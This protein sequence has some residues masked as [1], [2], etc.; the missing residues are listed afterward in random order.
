MDE[1]AGQVQ[2]RV[3]FLLTQ[4]QRDCSRLSMPVTDAMLLA[5]VC[6]WPLTVKQSMARS[7]DIQQMRKRQLEMLVEGQ[8][9]TLS[10]GVTNLEKK[11]EKIA[12]AGSLAPAEVHTI[13]KRISGAQE[14][15]ATMIAEAGD[16][17]RQEKLLQMALTDNKTRLNVV[18]KALAPLAQLWSVVRAWV[19]KIN[20][21]QHDPLNTVDAQDAEKSTTELR[22]ALGVAVR[23]L[24][25]RGDARATP[26]RAGKLLQQ[27]VKIFD[28]EQL[29]LL[30]LVCQ[31]GMKDRHWTQIKKNTRL[32]SLDI[33]K[34]SNLLQMLDVGLQHYAGVIEESCVAAGHEHGLEQQLERMEGS[35]RTMN[36]SII[37]WRGF[38]KLDGTLDIQQV[39]AHFVA[40]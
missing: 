3:H 20:H 30:R 5:S 14:L 4:T 11:I 9:E 32:D 40:L 33:T 12:E 2:E 38:H 31:P 24:E 35:W 15:L 21:W 28:E 39:C 16:I 36:F 13:Y 22:A 10:R 18:E 23:E 1:Y 6:Q 26:I 27:E 34:Q 37:S 19:E 7:H 8:Q 25:E 17:Q 29:P